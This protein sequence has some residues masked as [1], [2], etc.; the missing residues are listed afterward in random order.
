MGSVLGCKLAPLVCALVLSR[1]TACEKGNIGQKPE[2]LPGRPL[3]LH[4]EETLD[5]RED[6]ENKEEEPEQK[7]GRC[8]NGRNSR[9]TAE[10]QEKEKA[11]GEEELSE[12]TFLQ[13]RGPM[14]QRFCPR[15]NGRHVVL[16]STR[17]ILA[18]GD[19][20]TAGYYASGWRFAPYGAALAEALLPDIQAEVWV[21]GLSGLTAREMAAKQNAR[22]L[23]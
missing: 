13:E 9:E 17:R 14:P 5:S 19:S 20:L 12:E 7:R 11:D 8:A 6:G 21:C 23:Q 10:V 4:M 2:Q 18:F 15:P 22:Q 1:A 3:D 16:P